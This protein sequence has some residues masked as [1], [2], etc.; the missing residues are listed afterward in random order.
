[1]AELIDDELEHLL[2]TLYS[3]PRPTLDDINNL[4]VEFGEVTRQKTLILDMDETLMHAKLMSQADVSFNPDFKFSVDDGEGGK[5]EFGMKTR[6]QLHECLER[7]AKL[8]KICIFIAAERTYAEK[9][10][11]FSI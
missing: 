7:I 9:C 8:Y 5:L 3:L 10:I 6:P 11:S 1:M 2:Y 4:K